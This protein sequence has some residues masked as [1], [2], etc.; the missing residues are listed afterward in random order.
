[1]NEDKIK[2]MSENIPVPDSLTPENME[3]RLNERKKISSINKRAHITKGMMATA[4]CFLVLLVGASTL[5]AL[6][7]IKIDTNALN[8]SQSSLT[9]AT[10]DAPNKITYEN[11]RQII[12]EKIEESNYKDGSVNYEM[13]DAVENSASTE[14]AK[15]SSGSISEDKGSNDYT[16]T[17]IQEEGVDEGDVVKTDGKYI[18]S[19]NEDAFGNCIKIV[20]ADGKHTKL[21]SSISL[22]GIELS[23]MYISGNRLIALGCESN[24]DEING[25]PQDKTKIF[26]YDLTDIQNPKLLFEKKQSGSYSN[27]RKTGNYLYTISTMRV[28]SADS[29]DEKKRYIPSIDD[30]LF[31]EDK[32]FCPP[33]VSSTEYLVFTAL[34]VT[35]DGTFSDSLSVLGGDGICYV[36]TNNLYIVTNKGWGKSTINK[37]EYKDG[38]IDYSCQKS[39]NGNILNQFSM[40]EYNGYL[41]FVATS[42]TDKTSSNGLYV[43][44][45]KLNRVGSVSNLARSERIYSARFLGDK[46]YFVTYRETDPVFYVDL[47]DPKHPIVKDELKIPGFSNYLHPFSDNLL[48]GIG[49][50]NDLGNTGRAK[51]S[52][53]NIK[54]GEKLAEQNKLLLDN[55]TTTSAG[56]DYK[57]VLVDKK[58]NRIGFFVTCYMN[59]SNYFVLYSYDKNKGFQKVAKLDDDSTNSSAYSRGMFIGNY[60]YLTYSGYKTCVYD[61]NSFKLIKEE[62]Y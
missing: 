8:K 23:E 18:Y 47:K 38:K 52:M 50:E 35:G 26:V 3:K 43:M 34:D 53:F 7:I 48:L 55:D 14:S 20:K 16:H 60:F 59:N 9:T 24:P 31:N 25:N 27:S 11:F 13:N 46:A 12:N 17:N 28:Y 22:D 58:R 39:F 36:S 44:D 45:A 1:M 49:S 29:D 54:D 33:E 15:T 30:T 37:F 32:M 62:V 21:I 10:T 61:V 51:L 6:G 4:A 19:F 2:K 57:S 41:R 5:Y 40:D 56:N 42:N